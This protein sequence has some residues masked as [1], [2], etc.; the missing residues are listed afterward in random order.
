VARVL[1]VDDEPAILQLLSVSLEARGHDVLAAPH[2][3]LA[4]ELV[5]CHRLTGI[6]LIVSDVVMPEMNGPDLVR[7]IAKE[8]PGVTTLFISGLTAWEKLPAGAAFLPKPFTLLEL[9]SK[10]DALLEADGWR[11]HWD[12]AIRDCFDE[13]LRFH[14]ELA[15]ASSF[16]H[17]L[18]LEKQASDAQ[19]R[20]GVMLSRVSPV[21][22]LSNGRQ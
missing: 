15:N 6:D 14:A 1:V 2:P 20:L 16:T 7:E 17:R 5:K 9:L 22:H 19:L 8:L 3:R 13:L 21:Q 4:L 10:V 18:A 11:K 12:P